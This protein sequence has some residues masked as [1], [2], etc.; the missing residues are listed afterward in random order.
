MTIHE[1]LL[2]KLRFRLMKIPLYFGFMIA[3]VFLTINEIIPLQVSLA[4]IY[5]QE[6]FAVIKKSCYN[7]RP[8]VFALVMFAGTFGFVLMV[9]L[10]FNL[11]FP[12]SIIY[13]FCRAYPHRKK[14]MHDFRL[15]KVQ[16][17]L[18]YLGLYV[19]IGTA[20]TIIGILDPLTLLIA[21]AVGVTAVM[22]RIL[23][24]LT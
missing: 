2:W 12:I 14:F 3:T 24:F 15:P 22:I 7:L 4:M 17:T 16:E 21:T 1:H 5:H 6:I 10:G 20:M 11:I 23:V 13:L 18:R 8:E 9:A 19:G